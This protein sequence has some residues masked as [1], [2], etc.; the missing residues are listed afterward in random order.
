MSRLFALCWRSLLVLGLVL[1]P[2]VGTGMAMAACGQSTPMATKAPPCHHAMAMTAAA[3]QEPA[4]HAGCDHGGC[5][6]AACCVA[7]TLDV[8]SLS[9][10]AAQ[11][12]SQAARASYPVGA[13][14]P[15]PARM[16]RPPFG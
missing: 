6:F 15:P 11:P 1:N 8:P 4:G 16:I 10:V 7:G 9:F 2:V 13:A 3:K 5:Q 14:A 12:A